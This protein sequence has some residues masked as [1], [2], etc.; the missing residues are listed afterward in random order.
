MKEID[1]IENTNATFKTDVN[2]KLEQGWQITA[3]SYTVVFDGVNLV[4]NVMIER[5]KDSQ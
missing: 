5:I 3:A 4:Y 2:T 1:V